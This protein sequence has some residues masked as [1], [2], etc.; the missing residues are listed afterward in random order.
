M[1]SSPKASPP[2]RAGDETA[3]EAAGGA[4]DPQTDTPAVP[5]NAATIVLIRPAD[6]PGAVSPEVYMVRRS[7]KSPFMPSTLVFPG[8]RLDDADGDPADPATWERAA[9]REYR[10]EAALDLTGETMTWFDT[11]LTPSMESRRRYLARFFLV[12]LPAGH[13]QDA[14]ADGWETHE[15]RWASVD[16]HLQEW[17][18]GEVDLPPPTVCILLQLQRWADGASSAVAAVAAVEAAAQT[19][20]P[21]AAILPKV[22]AGR[23]RRA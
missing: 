14:E 2:K 20:T 5:R 4:P 23:P 3:A 19:V 7:A 18:R 17:E 1:A 9:Q 12:A 15:G 6:E 16:A 11:W 21:D 22:G 8:G 13:G 10:E